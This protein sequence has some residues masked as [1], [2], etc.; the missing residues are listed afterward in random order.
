MLG[1]VCRACA[2]CERPARTRWKTTSTRTVPAIFDTCAREALAM[3]HKHTH[4]EEVAAL[5]MCMWV[6]VC[7]CAHAKCPARTRRG[8]QAPRNR[9][10][11]VRAR[12][13]RNDTQHNIGRR[14]A[15]RDGHVRLCSVRHASV[16]RAR[17]QKQ[18]AHVRDVVLKHVRAR[19][20]R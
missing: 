2:A 4:W 15:C 3:T 12:D 10:P 9:D 16:L 13:T 5:G 18:R 7:V 20:S 19:R 17:V 6:C 14:W 1:T 8:A 11:H